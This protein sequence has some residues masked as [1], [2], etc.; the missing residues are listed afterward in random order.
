MWNK[1]ET[2]L[3]NFKYPS[4]AEKVLAFL[5]KE[6]LDYKALKKKISFAGRNELWVGQGRK[7]GEH[8][9]LAFK[10]GKFIGYG[11]YELYHQ[12][13]SWEKILKLTIPV[14]TLPKKIKN[15]MQIAYLKGEFKVIKINS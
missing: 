2:D 13:L 10:G 4:Q 5:Q 1:S 14:T 7:L 9:F 3:F 11:F 8:S 6:N 12:T 15:E